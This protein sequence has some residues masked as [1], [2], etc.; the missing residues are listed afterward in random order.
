MHVFVSFCFYD[1]RRLGARLGRR[2]GLRSDQVLVITCTGRA[3]NMVGGPLRVEDVGKLKVAELQARLEA[4][5]ESTKGKKA[6]LVARLVECLETRGE[7]GDE[8][9][10]EGER[11]GEEGERK[12]A[13]GEAA[14]GTATGG[15]KASKAANGGEVGRKETGGM[16]TTK[17]TT[18]PVTTK[19]TAS[20][21]MN[22]KK[23]MRKQKQREERE[24]LAEEEAT[25]AKGGKDGKD[26]KGGK[27]GRSQEVVYVEEDAGKVAKGM[28]SEEEFARIVRRFN[29]EGDGEGGIGDG[30]SEGGRGRMDGGDLGGHLGG[31]L[32]EN[33]DGNVNAGA[34]ANVEA[35]AGTHAN[36]PISKRAMKL[37]SRMKIG[38]LKQH[39]M[40]PELVESWDVTAADPLL[41]V[42]LKAARNTVPVPRHWSQKR[43]Y[44][45][46]KKGIEKP[47]FQLPAFIAATGIGEM[48]QAYNDDA[49]QES[50]RA[51]GKAR[52]RPKMN[53]M[54]IDYRVLYDAFFKHQETPLKGLSAPGELYYE[55]KEY[56]LRTTHAKPG[57][58]SDTLMEALGMDQHVGGGRLLPPPWLVSMQ[59]YGP[60][61]GYPGLSIPGLNAPIPPGAQFGY[62]PG[63]WG[64][65]PVDQFG[66]PIYG[67]VFGQAGGWG[68]E[69]EDERAFGGRVYWG[70]VE[71][72]GESSSSEEESEEEEDGGEGPGEEEP[73]EPEEE[74]TRLPASTMEQVQLRKDSVKES[75]QLYEVLEQ[76]SASALKAGVM[77]TD[78]V[79]DMG[80]GRKTKKVTGAAAKRLEALKKTMPDI[81][82]VAI[83]P[84][85]LETLDDAAIKELYDAKVAESRKGRGLTEVDQMMASHLGDKKRKAES[86]K[87]A[88]KKEKKFKF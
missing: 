75:K 30:E 46:G 19:L 86:G 67:D 59:R 2:L 18:M 3:F 4:L 64:K 65:P 66:N 24:R 69:E 63:G 11:K 27:K 51:Q 73:E 8:K 57:V 82:D 38:E 60:P 9:G 71:D 40:R 76:K 32:G 80:G 20:Q 78:H 15:T 17:T 12:G 29:G 7:E 26:G 45:Q 42:H 49:E 70:E 5:G 55:G 36:Q 23:K 13:E 25:R 83:D 62:H 1:W 58:L 79:Y 68:E 85:D 72:A 56:E 44:L 33:A 41:L 21:R 87:G 39:T 52:T 77:G 31:D 22:L 37:A 14:E 16:T 61:P 50:L 84:S 10:A 34:N 74:P 6:V 47:P 53:R 81:M 88:G 43:R 54:D 48:R 28:M 35:N